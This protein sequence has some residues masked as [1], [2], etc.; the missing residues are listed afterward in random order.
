MPT[1]R[2]S[3]RPC[4]SRTASAEPRKRN[5]SSRPAATARVASSSATSGIPKSAITPPPV[6]LT[7]VP[8][9]PST[10]VRR[11][12]KYSASGAPGGLLGSGVSHGSESVAD[13]ESAVGCQ[14]EPLTTCQAG[15]EHERSGWYRH[16]TARRCS[17]TAEAFDRARPALLPLRVTPGAAANSFVNGFSRISGRP[18]R[19]AGGNRTPVHQAP[20]ARA[21]TIPDLRPD[22]GRLTGQLA[23][24]RRWRPTNRLS[25]SSSVFPDVSCLSRCHPPLL[26][27]GCGGSA[28]CAI[29]G[30][31]VSSLT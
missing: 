12:S 13:T 15:T 26:L 19:G 6:N 31:D 28:P 23:V 2:P 29:S 14:S 5:C 24:I 11:I 10:V 16:L 9:C 30:H 3:S 21:T 22:A 17:R 20:S 4:R 27:P 1:R 7:T 8:A 25:E 18:P